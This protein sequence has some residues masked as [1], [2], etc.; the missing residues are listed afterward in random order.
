MLSLGVLVF[1][2]RGEWGGRTGGGGLLAGREEAVFSALPPVQGPAQAGDTE[3]RCLMVTP[4]H[5]R[6]HPPLGVLA[7]LPRPAAKEVCLKATPSPLI[8]RPPGMKV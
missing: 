3:H 7:H 1:L 4:I 2:L 6:G 5:V 8:F